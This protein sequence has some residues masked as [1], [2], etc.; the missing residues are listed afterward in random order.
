MNIAFLHSMTVVD[1][2]PIFLRYL[3]EYNYDMEAMRVNLTEIAE[4]AKCFI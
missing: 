1:G 4:D 2:K 3:E